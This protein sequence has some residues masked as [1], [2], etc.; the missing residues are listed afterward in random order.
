[1]FSKLLSLDRKHVLQHVR[2]REYRCSR[3][4]LLEPRT[5]LSIS[6]VGPL[7]LAHTNGD[8]VVADI[9]AIWPPSPSAVA[10]A[11]AKSSSAVVANAE[12]IHTVVTMEWSKTS[13]LTIRWKAKNG[14]KIPNAQV[15]FQCFNGS[16]SDPNSQ[17]SPEGWRFPITYSK[18]GVAKV[19]RDT[20]FKMMGA[21]EGPY[22]HAWAA[23]IPWPMTD[24]PYGMGWT[25]LQIPEPDLAVTDFTTNMVHSH[26]D[27][28]LKA[29]VT[30]VNQGTVESLPF[31]MTFYARA[32]PGPYASGDLIL[33]DVVRPALKAGQSKTYEVKIKDP[34]YVENTFTSGYFLGVQVDPDNKIPE[35]NEDN[36]F[37]QEDGSSAAD[38]AADMAAT[39]AALAA[40]KSAGMTTAA[41]NLS[42]YLDTTSDDSGTPRNWSFGTAAS[43]E[44]ENSKEF[45]ASVKAACRFLTQELLLRYEGGESA[46]ATLDVPQ[47]VIGTPELR[48]D[49]DL[50][51]AFAGTRGS[52]GRFEAI[53]L[54]PEKKGN[55]TVITFTAYLRITY[56]DRYEFTARDAYFGPWGAHEGSC[57]RHLQILGYTKPFDDSVTAHTTVSGKF[58]V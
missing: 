20:V 29:T 54:K 53:Q 10:V 42:H 19:A 1:M 9:P 44:L 38:T 34:I 39:L 8:H 25:E 31:H 13:G 49:P 24:N 17:P 35:T 4:E 55:R 46:P 18:S 26:A 51:M 56:T 12:A 21:T 58:M 16:Y 7:P 43:N 52:S 11:D 37:K 32:T 14:D 50:F 5:L 2:Q 28:K 22:D 27:D 23:V 30:L 36:N 3:F 48:S 15:R 47:K 57:Q 40:F 6:T 45:K 33:A 41:E